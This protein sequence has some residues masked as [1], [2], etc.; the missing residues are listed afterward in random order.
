MC[1]SVFVNTPGK[2]TE[3][4]VFDCTDAAL[5]SHLFLLSP[6]RAV[7]SAVPRVAAAMNRKSPRSHEVAISLVKKNV[8]RNGISSFALL[9]KVSIQFD[10]LGRGSASLHRTRRLMRVVAS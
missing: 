8:A 7:A 2:M 5:K 10:K 9:G 3:Y 1:K 6:F 4:L